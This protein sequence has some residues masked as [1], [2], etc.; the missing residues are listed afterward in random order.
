VPEHWSKIKEVSESKSAFSLLLFLV[1]HLPFSFLRFLAYPISFFYYL[2][3]KDARNASK[4]YIKHILPF[5]KKR[6]LSSY[7]HFVSFSI[8]LLEKVR[9]WSGRSEDVEKD[10]GGDLGDLHERLK[11]KEG[12]LFIC[13]HLGNSEKLRALAELDEA[14]TEEKISLISIVDFAVTANFNLMLEKLNPRAM[15]NTISADNIGPDTIIMLS[16]KLKTGSLIV[17]AGDRVSANS[18]KTID[19]P[20]LGSTAP[21][22]FGP[23]YLAALLNT[24]SYFVFGLRAFDKFSAPYKMFVHKINMDFNCPRAERIEKTKLLAGVFVKYLEQYV[25]EYPY[26]WY[27]FF[28]FWKDANG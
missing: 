16:D 6:S 12:V 15:I 17:I 9:A 19:L 18:Q 11:N 10:F 13:S 4:I 5:T 28:D 25:T 14:G 7:K 8:T 23:F 21:F 1:K 3:A 20:F 26:Q 24:N 22:P 2:F 27:N